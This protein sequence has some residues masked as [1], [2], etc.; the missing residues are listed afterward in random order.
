MADHEAFMRRA[1]E[2]SRLA[3]ASGQTPFGAVV[4]REGRILAEAH[5]RV[6]ATGDPTAHGEINAIRLATQRLGSIDLTGCT[7]Y[8]SCEPCP[9]CLAA[10]HWARL[11]ALCRG[12]RIADAEAAGF[13][14][15]P[16]A[17]E[18]MMEQGGCSLELLPDCLRDEAA[19]VLRDFAANHPDRLY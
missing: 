11:S 2:L 9:M 15:M 7:I 16:I 8:S 18:A 17:N 12:A 3:V 13:R 1:I 4:V 19:A 10:I 14:E 6:W 5:N